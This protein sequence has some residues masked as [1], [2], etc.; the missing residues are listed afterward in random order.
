MYKKNDFEGIYAVLLF[1][2]YATD[3]VEPGDQATGLTIPIEEVDRS[4]ILHQLG[5]FQHL[6]VF[7]TFLAVRKI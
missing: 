1:Y 5:T 2:K 4:I 3:H 7:L 6:E